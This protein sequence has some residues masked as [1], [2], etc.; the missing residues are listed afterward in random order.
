VSGRVIL[1]TTEGNYFGSKKESSQGAPYVLH[2]RSREDSPAVAG[3]IELAEMINGEDMEEHS[4]A[5]AANSTGEVIS[6]SREGKMKRIRLK[7]EELAVYS[8]GASAAATR[9]VKIDSLYF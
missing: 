8:I 4:S 9:S 1:S 2:D 7:G 5:A 6:L 3:S